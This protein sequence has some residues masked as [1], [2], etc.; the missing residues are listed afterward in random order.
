MSPGGV[1]DSAL[2]SL[3]YVEG[4]FANVAGRVGVAPDTVLLAALTTALV[5]VAYVRSVRSARAAV[6]HRRH[7]YVLLRRQQAE[8]GQ[9]QPRVPAAPAL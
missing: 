9:Q 2:S 3:A 7:Q 6:M 1:V 4:A 8:L 5:F